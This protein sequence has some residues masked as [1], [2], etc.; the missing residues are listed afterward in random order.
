MPQLHEPGDGEEAQ[1]EGQHAHRRLGGEQELSPVEV[2]G[3]EAGPAAATEPAGPNCS[4]MTMPT[5]VALL[6][7][8]WVRT[9][10]SWAV[11]CIQVPT[12]DTIAPT[13][14]VR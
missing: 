7:V 14:H 9:I 1:P 4:A 12:L 2:I 11:R 6:W 10:Q 5:A 13:A 8:S 3:R